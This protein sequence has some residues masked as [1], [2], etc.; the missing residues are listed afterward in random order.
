MGEIIA[1]NMLSLLI[2]NNKIIIVASSRLFLELFDVVHSEQRD[3]IYF[4]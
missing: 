2:I 3:T 1:R 4:V